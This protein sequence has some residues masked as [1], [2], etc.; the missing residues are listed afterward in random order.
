MNKPKISKGYENLKFLNSPD[1]RII[2]ILAEY[3][4]PLQR[5]RRL[6]IRDTIVFYGSAR[7]EDLKAAKANFVI[8]KKRWGGKKTPEAIQKQKAAQIAIKM[9]HYYED[10]MEL[11]YRLTAWSKK[12]DDGHQRFVI[13][14][15]GGP[16][17]MEAANRGARKAGGKNIGLNISLPYEQ[18]P[19]PYISSEL[20]F[21]FHYFFIRKFWFAYM[22]KA[23][24]I[25]P[26]GFGTLDELFEILTLVQTKKIKKKMT[27][28]IYGKEYWDQILNF[29]AM[30]RHNV[31]TREDANLFKFF[32]DVDSAFQY[33]KKE[34]TKN[35]LHD[36]F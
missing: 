13:C 19:N 8:V 4:E 5:F 29:E 34:L 16:G 1:G 17:M 11:A 35:Y 31:I 26:G 23:L 32:S 24:V 14:S 18:I 10:A 20:N 22:A 15:G 9:A 28:V 30:I 3:M 25:F 36:R 33:L 12:L 7:T 6:G 21:E 27:I 2:R